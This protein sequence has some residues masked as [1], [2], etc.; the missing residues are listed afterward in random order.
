[1]SDQM[2]LSQ[3][4]EELLARGYKEYPPNDV[5]DGDADALFQRQVTQDGKRLYFLNVR[6][7]ALSKYR[8]DLHD[9]CMLVAT[10]YL[11]EEPIKYFNMEVNID[12]LQ[13]FAEAEALI[14]KAYCSMGC[15]PDVLN[16]D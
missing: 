16:N 11:A 2:L 1:M 5:V 8:E 4:R 15:I 12:G 9:G 7:Y 10:L 3:W 14:S 13:D 6:A